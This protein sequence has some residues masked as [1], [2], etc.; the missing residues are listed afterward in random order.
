MPTPYGLLVL[1]KHIRLMYVPSS[2]K[3]LGVAWLG[4]E[5]GGTFGGTP[6]WLRSKKGT[7]LSMLTVAAAVL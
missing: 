1:V 3:R 5:G 7:R 4:V 6:S 2:S